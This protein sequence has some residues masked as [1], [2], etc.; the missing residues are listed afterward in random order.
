MRDLAGKVAVVTGGGSGIGRGTV[1]ALA[2]AGMNIVIGDIN[3][4]AASNVVEEV[5]GKGCRAIA[6]KTDVS[7]RASVEALADAAWAEFGDV[8]VLHNNAGVVLF[9]PLASMSDADW[10]WILQINLYGV[11]NGIQAFLPRMRAA[12]GE[13]H[14][15]NTAS[16]AGHFAAA[17]LGAYNTTKY[18]VVGL[19]EALHAE[20]APEGIGVS[21]LCPGGVSTNIMTTMLR[22]RPPGGADMQAPNT[23]G[24]SLRMIETDDVGRMVRHAIETNELYIFTHPEFE[25]I[26]RARHERILAAFERWRGP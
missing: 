15:V 23:G 19:S 3:E 21:V 13:R 26:V 17:T 20:L 11:V 12:G 7:D 22:D 8:H 18:A 5:Q 6:V 1:L 16:M 14:I 24:G 4:V 10:N 25:E 9:L 2:D